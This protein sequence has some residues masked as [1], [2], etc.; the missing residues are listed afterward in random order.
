MS[1]EAEKPWYEDPFIQEMMGLMG[2]RSMRSVMAG[3][4][5]NLI[6]SG[7]NGIADA[8]RYLDK[9]LYDNEKRILI[10]ADSFTQKFS[11]IIEKGFSKYKFEFQIWDGAKPE[12]P[13]PTIEEGVKICEE[14]QPVVIMAI[15][16]G[17][18]MDTAKVVNI[19]YERPELNLLQID[20]VSGAIGLHRKVKHLVAIPT[21]IGTGSE[22][23]TTAILNDTR[24]EPHK[25]IGVTCDDILPSIVILHPD[26]VKNLPQFL[27]IGTGLDT[28]AHAMG[29]YVS[30]WNNPYTSA[31][32]LTAI[33]ETIH[34]LPRLVKY[35]SKDLEAWEHMQ[36]AALMAGLGFS[37]AM[38]GIEHALGH[39][40]GALMNT[41][42][43]LS[44]GLFT[45][46]SVAWQAKVTERWRNL[47]P[48]FDLDIKG[49]PRQQALEALVHKI[50]GF[51]RKVDG[52]ASVSEFKH[53]IIKKEDFQ[54]AIPL[55]SEFALNDIAHL[56][57]YR[58]LKLHHYKKMF[59]AAWDS[60]KLVY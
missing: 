23:T 44:V 10:I 4:K 51:I 12:V 52:A 54:K 11:S 3:F 57:S 58:P 35:G 53:P 47:C 59:E 33:K 21:T 9:S 28:F 36:W 56:A 2:G 31:I 43:G 18:V 17:S 37:N 5:S 55:M 6:Y 49:M 45:P 50:Q 27:I 41:H 8:A 29:A 7:E 38:P 42:H 48:L 60:K 24:R 40:F 13:Y 1:D 34:Y 39:S 19:K 30:N 25:K 15:G 26:F 22:A 20:V 16:G 14:F 32:N 46:Q